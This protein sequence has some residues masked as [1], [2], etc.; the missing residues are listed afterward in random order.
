MARP[1]LAMTM[2]FG[3]VGITATL[4]YLCLALLLQWTCALSA[5]LASV[6]A[7]AIAALFSYFAHRNFTFGATNSHATAMPRFTVTTVCGLALSLALPLLL[8]DW[9]GLPGYVPFIAVCVLV[10][11]I[12][13][14][15]L[16]LWVFPDSGEQK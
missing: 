7:Y 5:V 3:S 14:V 2:R 1:L 10:P 9:L 12:N 11:V 8:H 13:L 6:M 15:V 16:R 4:L